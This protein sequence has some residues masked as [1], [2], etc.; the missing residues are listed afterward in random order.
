MALTSPEGLVL[1][2]KEL[3]NFPG[4]FLISPRPIPKVFKQFIGN[5][6]YFPEG[7]ISFIHQ[8]A[9]LETRSF[10]YPQKGGS[11]S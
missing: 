10:S 8:I 9:S 1:G 2:A 11:R 4:S 5:V 7:I 6:G 3:T